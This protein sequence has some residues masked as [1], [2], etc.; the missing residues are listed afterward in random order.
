MAFY[1]ARIIFLNSNQIAGILH[2]YTTYS[3]LFCLTFQNVDPRGMLSVGY[4]NTMSIS[5]A[6]ALAFSVYHGL[7]SK[8]Q[9]TKIHKQEICFI[10]TL[11]RLD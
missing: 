8:L 4:T 5:Q 7:I 9:A 6:C 2:F 10:A 3:I 11:K 1:T